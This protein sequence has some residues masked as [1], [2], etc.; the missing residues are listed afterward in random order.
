MSEEPTAAAEVSAHRV[1]PAA[2]TPEA[3]QSTVQGPPADEAQAADEAGPGDEPQPADEPQAKDPW[4]NANLPWQGRPRRVD[5]LCW[6]AITASGLYYLALLPFRASLV[7]THPIVSVLLNGS[8]EAIVSAA[9]YARVG[10]GSIVVVLLAGVFGTMKFDIIYWW[11]G[12]LW[13]ERVIHMFSGRG[14][15]SQKFVERVNRLG[16][17]LTW[18][19]VVLSPFLPIPNALVYAA[20][21]W[22]GMSWVT[23]LILD[24]IG[25]LAFVGMLAGLGWALGQ[26]AVNVAQEISKYGLW[27]TIAI[28]VLVVA[29]QMR[30]AKARR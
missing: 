10:H 13:G 18:P 17:R 25:S 19:A 8:T 12:R 14:K 6:G 26:S 16:W 2:P 11:A 29:S 23:F 27:V 9:A 21:G 15:R 4:A 5:V 7:G 20:A 24:A 30:G 1:E 3:A 28:V 22:T